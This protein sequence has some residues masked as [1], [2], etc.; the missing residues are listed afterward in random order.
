MLVKLVYRCVAVEFMEEI[1]N[2]LIYLACSAI[3]STALP[4]IFIGVRI[5]AYGVLALITQKPIL[6]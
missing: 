4:L 1:A 3:R 2:L 6:N 5:A